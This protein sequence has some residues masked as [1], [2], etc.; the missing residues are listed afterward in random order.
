VSEVAL[1]AVG[2]EAG[3]GKIAVVRELDL[4][5]RAGEVLA[6]FGSNGAGKTTTVRTLA[7]LLS[8]MDGEVRL[9]GQ[10]VKSPLHARARMGLSLVTE[11]RAL[12]KTLSVAENLR[13]TRSDVDY[14]L[15]LFPE[16]GEHLGR[17]AG[18]LSG[19]QQQMLSLAR[20]LAR[21]PSVLLI[22]ELSLGL[23]PIVVNRLLTAVRDAADAGM[24]VLLVEQ[25]IGK[26]LRIADRVHVLRRGR[27]VL[28][29]DAS[30]FRD[31]T[32][33]IVLAYMA[34]E[35]EEIPSA[36]L[37]GRSDRREEQKR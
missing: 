35:E 8:A 26:A 28:E 3:Y 15:E 29:G 37:N 7:G 14:A 11:R 5:L 27:I 1:Q 20:A 30:R 4:E 16:L 10:A 13:V 24:A 36:A 9:G 25:H 31:R 19:G 6:L 17:P 12:V 18:L 34:E 32:N 33:E 2:L 23:A 21:R 22:D